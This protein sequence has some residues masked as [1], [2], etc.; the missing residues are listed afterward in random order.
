MLSLDHLSPASRKAREDAEPVAAPAAQDVRMD[1]LA[2]LDTLSPEHREVIVLREFQ[3]MSYDEIA[4]ALG[5][6]RGTVESRLFRA[7]QELKGGLKD[8]LP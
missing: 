4:E 3:G 7:R 2:T 8:Y 5:V 6:P 1:V